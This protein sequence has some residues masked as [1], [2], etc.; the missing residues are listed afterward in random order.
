MRKQL[1][2]HLMPFHHRGIIASWHDRLIGAGK[3]WE[4]SISEHIEKADI[5]ILLVS[6]DFMESSYC[7][8]IEVKR[9]LERH[10][11]GTARVIPVIVRDV[12]WTLAPFAKLQVLPRDARAVRLWP[13]RDRAWRNVVEGIEAAV[14]EL[15]RERL[16]AR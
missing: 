14:E 8:D 6:S 13:D 9:A 16:G 5:I 7:W 12:M 10:E 1:G 4:P 11:D 3:E 2:A 15:Q